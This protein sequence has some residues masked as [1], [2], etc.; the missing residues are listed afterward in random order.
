M[1]MHCMRK[2]PEAMRRWCSC[3]SLLVPMSI[4]K[5]GNALCVASAKGHETVVPL[6]LEKDA[7]IKR[8]RIQFT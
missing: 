1:E 4:L 5:A 8:L 3:W 6:L 2:Q 7:D